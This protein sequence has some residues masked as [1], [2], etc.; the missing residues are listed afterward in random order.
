ML[1]FSQRLH[2]NFAAQTVTRIFY[3][4]GNLIH[5]KAAIVENVLMTYRYLEIKSA[6][7]AN[8]ALTNDAYEAAPLKAT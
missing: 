7:A 2:Q 1:L 5:S 3:E 4:I 8:L 6:D